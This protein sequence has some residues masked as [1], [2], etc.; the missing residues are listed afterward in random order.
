MER[1]SDSFYVL[2]YI[3]Y[4]HACSGN[5]GINSHIAQFKSDMTVINAVITVDITYGGKVPLAST[6]SE[7]YPVCS[8]VERHL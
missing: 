7:R 2:E 3:Y 8:T 5:G 6:V 4:T 1:H